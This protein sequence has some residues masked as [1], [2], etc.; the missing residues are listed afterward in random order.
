MGES[1]TGGGG[2]AI[3]RGRVFTSIWADPGLELWVASLV[4]GTGS[5]RHLGDRGSQRSASRMVIPTVHPGVPA[6]LKA[7]LS[8]DSGLLG[9]GV[10]FALVGGFVALVYLLTTTIL[11]LVVHLPFQLALAIGFCVAITVH[12]TLQR[13]FV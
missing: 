7:A 4:R 10:R 13:V 12:F 8:P 9:Q 1:P 6:F 2:P 3:E 11:A 5:H